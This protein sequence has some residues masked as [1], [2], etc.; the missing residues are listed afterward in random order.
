MVGIME[1]EFWKILTL[2]IFAAFSTCGCIIL[3]INNRRASKNFQK[4]KEK[5]QEDANNLCLLMGNNWKITKV[6]DLPVR[7]DYRFCGFQASDETRER[8][9][10]AAVKRQTLLSECNKYNVPVPQ[11]SPEEIQSLEDS[12]MVKYLSKEQ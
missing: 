7:E 5:A 3:W 9:F 11:V 8:T 1:I 10:E 4:E 2:T 12:A 6:V